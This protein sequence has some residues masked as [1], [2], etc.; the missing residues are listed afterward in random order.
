MTKNNYINPQILRNKYKKSNLIIKLNK[1][2]MI[3]KLKI[4]KAISNKVIAHKYK[5]QKILRIHN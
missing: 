5:I 4:R 3:C 2:I 1:I